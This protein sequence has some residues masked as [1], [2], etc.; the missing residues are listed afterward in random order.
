MRVGIKLLVLSIILTSQT[1]YAQ[2]DRIEYNNQKLFLS[3][4][5][6]AWLSF[7]NDIGAG[8]MDY[9][10]FADVLLQ[11]HDNGGNSLRWWIHT[12]GSA[13]P[14]FDNLGK[15]T[16]PGTTTIQE[17]RKAL[18]LA[19]EREVGVVL[20]LWS[21]DMM[22]KNKPTEVQYRN[23]LLLT[24]T[25]YTREYINKALIPMV[26]SLKGHPA[27]IAWEIFNEPEGMTELLT[28]SDVA[29]VDITAIQR[30]VNLCA[31]AI[32][33]S[34]PNSFVTNGSVS[35]S[36]ISDI[37]APPLGKAADILS[38]YSTRQK[39]EMEE[40]FFNKYGFKQTADEL[41]TQFQINAAGY[42]YYSDERL[43][44]AGGDPDGKL[45]FYTF[46]YYSWQ[47]DVISPFIKSSSTW[48]LDKPIVVGEVF[49]QTTSGFPVNQLYSSVY[50][51]GYAGAW[52]WAWT[53]NQVTSKANILVSLKSIWDNYKQDVDVLGISGDWPKVEI[54]SPT[55]NTKF[56][57]NAEV[58]ITAEA[59]DADGTITKVEFFANDSLK[60][61]E[62]ILSPYSVVWTNITNGEYRLTAIATDDKGH[63][64]TSNPVL[65]IIGTPTLTKLEAE[66][67]KRVGSGISIKSDAN[68]SKG[69]YV[70]LAAQT[71]TL[72]W[73]FNNYL[74][75][76]NYEIVFGYRLAYETPKGQY[77]NVNGNRITELMFDGA[78]NSWLE[79][80]LN[81]DLVNGSNSV[82]MEAS[83]GWM[84]VDYL[85]V[86][87]DLV[88]NVNQDFQI[89]ESFSL[90]QNYPNPFN[91]TTIINYQ[92]PKSGFV[93]LKV[94]DVLGNEVA[95]LVNE[96][97]Q[98][99]VYK[100]QLAA[101]AFNLAS[102]VYFYRLTVGTFSD[103]K[104]MLL[105]K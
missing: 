27:I 81:V 47:G 87:T 40:A 71:W 59:S 23:N 5:N 3:G 38:H 30:F 98:A 102:G 18:D 15:V 56:T 66:A 46:H 9:K 22:R 41:I 65:I 26:D 91:P 8:K 21:F 33:R 53:D 89:S 63:Q 93:T 39:M 76:G 34:D 62:S 10:T 6:L 82:Q 75:A 44:A 11:V 7:A 28:W 77:I 103:T 45:D 70:D 105:I 97:M 72:T 64:R 58:T 79:K 48:N 55:N 85:A 51:N 101:N 61:G 94:Y 31:G 12:D 54:T 92:L 52:A 14:E 49:L 43:I 99:G 16:G 104:K 1:I 80:K 2:L 57:D 29:I 68:A 86:P 78:A 100:T 35:V 90:S 95:L 73:T 69:N 20:C 25:T 24:D 32:H 42:N 67:A 84:H 19:W 83:W 50:N 37:P 60:I 96:Y 13:S 88:T 74:E 4:T 17:L 36:F